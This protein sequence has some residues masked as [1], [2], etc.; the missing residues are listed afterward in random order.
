MSKSL[1]HEDREQITSDK[2][3]PWRDM[4][5]SSVFISGATGLI[6]SALL[7]A[8]SAA[9]DKHGLGMRLIAHSRDPGKGKTLSANAGTCFI[10]GDIR[11][12]I[13]QEALPQSIDYIFH[14]A[15]MTKSTEMIKKPA[16]VITAAVYG[17]VNMLDLA[18]EKH[19][20]GFVYLSSMEVYGQTQLRE[21][22]EGDLGYINLANPR[23]SYPESKRLCEV[24]CV[25]YAAQHGVPTKIARLAQ[26][27]GAGSPMDDTR[28]F[29]QFARSAVAGESIVLHTEGKSRG[30]YCYTSD[31]VL[32]LL[33]VLLK[34]KP[35]E[36][37]NIANPGASATIREMAELVADKVCG[38]NIKVVVSK[39]EDTG[40]LGYAPDTGYVLNA[41][42]LKALGW[43]PT[44]GLEEMYRRMIADW[45]GE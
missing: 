2:S 9:N 13:A 16:D 11:K 27:F 15:A 45:R 42:K 10:A 8:L 36:A 6:G 44:Y 18:R 43:I 32:G 35:G 41:D 30:N 19:C 26:T 29:A 31:A 24:L 25:A 21:V 28:V 38:G 40:K 7:G 22:R 39:A 20:R 17:T 4:S 23:S 34:G 3:I 37:Y 1:Q 5:G 33:A 12:P 14:C